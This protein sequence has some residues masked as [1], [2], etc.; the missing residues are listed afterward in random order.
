MET[1]ESS[2]I[3]GYIED[4]RKGAVKSNKDTLLTSISGMINKISLRWHRGDIHSSSSS[5]NNSSRSSSSN[6]SSTNSSM[7]CYGGV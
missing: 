4:R 2:G 5:N 7:L 3:K 1:N 6:S